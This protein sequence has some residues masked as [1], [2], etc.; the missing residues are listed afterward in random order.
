MQLLPSADTQTRTIPASAAGLAYPL[1]SA[2]HIYFAD[3]SA[4]FKCKLFTDRGPASSKLSMSKGVGFDISQFEGE[5]FTRIEFD[6][7]SS[8]DA[9]TVVY[10]ESNFEVRD[11]RAQNVR[12]E[13]S[14]AGNGVIITSPENTESG[15]TTL[16][17]ATAT[18]IISANSNTRAA[19][20]SNN[21]GS[22]VW[23][24][25]SGVVVGKGVLVPTGTSS[26]PLEVSSD[27]YAI[28]TSGGSVGH[29][30]FFFS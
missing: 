17:A 29:A 21:I 2:K 9:L 22:D 14:G 25:D 6:N 26:Q 1:A 20:V 16:P 3:A 10:W 23:V 30:R 5:Y 7:L 19:I 8:T 18:K 12:S 13:I 28:N 15:S 27:L 24:G 11:N 4:N